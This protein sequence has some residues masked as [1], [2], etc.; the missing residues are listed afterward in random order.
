MGF[1][2]RVLL[3]LVAL[4]PPACDTLLPVPFV[5]AVPCLG[6]AVIAVAFSFL[7]LSNVTSLGASMD[8]EDERG[9]AVLVSCFGKMWM[10]P[11]CAL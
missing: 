2:G 4:C 9:T 7:L 5:G 10:F 8:V 3:P 11:I 1:K 6:Q